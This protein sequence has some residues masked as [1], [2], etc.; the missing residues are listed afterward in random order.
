MK[1]R[2]WFVSA[3]FAAAVVCLADGEKLATLKVG[4]DTYT[5]VTVLS[6]TAT[7]IYFSHSLGMGNAKLKN[8]DPALQKT[9]HFN[10]D[11]AAEKEKQQTAEK[12]LY[13]QEVEKQKR[14]APRPT[15]PVE[16]VPGLP[17]LPDEVEPHEIAA[18]SFINQRAPAI[19]AEKWLTPPPPINGKFMLVDFWGTWS[20]PCRTVI[21]KLNSFASTFKDR[22]V[23]VG[24][25]DEPEEQVQKMTAPQ[26]QFPVAVDTQKR[27]SKAFGVE[28]I[29]HLV[30]VDPRGVV[31]FE[32]HPGYLDER[33]LE[34][35]LTRFAQ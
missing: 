18:K 14:T 6:V 35:L 22:L 3:W 15:A 29:P 4:A 28:R 25:T 7:D 13:A 23:V 16:D 21:P 33:K 31:R 26:I 19:L 12:A 34:K 10:A 9:F 27:A 32:G 2:F 1:K 20:E 17:G 11:R 30:L 5:N 8:L 24:L